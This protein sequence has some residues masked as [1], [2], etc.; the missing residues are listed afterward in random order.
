ME[1]KRIGS[2]RIY[3]GKIINVRRDEVEI[4]QKVY[5]REVVEH[6]GGVAI[7]AMNDQK[8]IFCVTQYRYAQ[9]RVMMELPAGKLEKGENPLLCAQRELQEE[10][11]YSA[12]TWNY[13]GELVPTGAY[14]E[15]KIYMY[16]AQDLSY[17]GQNL[18]ED[19]HVSVSQHCMEELVEMIMKNE[20]IDAK[21]IAMILMAQKKCI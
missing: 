13:L 7:L 12:K 21:T 3:E 6:H 11:G 8:E 16:F 14:L 20:I 15:E 18:D 9:Q 10:T 19:E 17:V 5:P 1:E 4:N 2:E